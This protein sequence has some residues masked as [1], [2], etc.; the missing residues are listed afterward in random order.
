MNKITAHK[1]ISMIALPNGIMYAYCIDKTDNV[2]RVGFKM[3]S[4]ESGKISNVSKSIFTL[5]KFG[6]AY[7]A[8]EDKIKNYL[9]C[10]TVL[11]EN[12]QIFIVELDGSALMID[13]DGTEIWSGRFTYQS[14]FPSSIT[15]TDGSLWAAYATKNVIVKYNLQALREELRI[16]GETSVFDSPSNLF[17]AGKKLFVCNSGNNE[18][19]KLDVSDYSTEKYYEFKEPLID[20]TFVG[21]YEIVALESGIY[22]L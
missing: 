10:S 17:P 15:V 18:I 20:Y 6:A 7:K 1:A 9:T 22:L 8:F 4:F 19:W 16:G 13:S 5:T 21:K 2:M 14:S 11:L 12:G 3:I